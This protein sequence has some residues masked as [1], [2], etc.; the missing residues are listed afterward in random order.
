MKLYKKK[1]YLIKN[2]IKFGMEENDMNKY[3]MN[4]YFH[5]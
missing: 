2:K 5:S 3:I 4:L 1:I